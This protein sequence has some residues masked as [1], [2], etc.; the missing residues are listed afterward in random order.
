MA[1]T[2][3]P[4]PVH[5][6]PFKR[7]PLRMPGQSIQDEMNR[8]LEDRMIPIVVFVGLFAVYALNDWMITLGLYRPMPRFTR[9]TSK[10]PKC[11]QG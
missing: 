7:K 6:S 5:R 8:L 11:P 2:V 3:F 4:K 9:A 1:I 10:S